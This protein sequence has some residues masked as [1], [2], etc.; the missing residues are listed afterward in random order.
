MNPKGGK[1]GTCGLKDIKESPA[2]PPKVDLKF[3]T[4]LK[5]LNLTSWWTK[6]QFVAL[7]FIHDTRLKSQQSSLAPRILAFNAKSSK[8][9]SL[10][11]KAKQPTHQMDFPIS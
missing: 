11:K 1:L 7:G 8:I 9:P 6:S 4:W 2:E 10:P 5:V 3:N